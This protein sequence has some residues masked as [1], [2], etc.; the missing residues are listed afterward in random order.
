MLPPLLAAALVLAA[1]EIP[2]AVARASAPPGSSFAG[3]ISNSEDIHAYFSFARQ[4]AEG[5]WLF[6]NRYA[7]A[8][9][10]PAYF[11][12]EWLVVGWCVR[13]FGDPGAFLVWRAAGAL[14]LASGFWAL[15]SAFD[16]KSVR[17]FALALFSLGGGLGWV[18]PTAHMLHVPIAAAWR[19]LGSFP[20]T[21]QSWGVQPFVQVLSN[22][23]FSTVT[24][25]VLLSLALLVRAERTR[26]ATT[27]VAAG[28][29]A[30]L[31]CLSRP[32]E[33][34]LFLAVV[35]ALHLLSGEIADVRAG[36]R[37]ACTLLV[38]AP[39]L[40][41]ISVIARNPSF[42]TWPGGAEM[43]VVPL[44]G[45]LVLLGPAVLVLLVRI[46]HARSL[47]FREPAER[48]MLL[49]LAAA[50]VLSQAN[51]ITDAIPYSPQILISCM[52]PVVMLAVPAVAGRAWLAALVLALALP[53]SA[54]TIARRCHEATVF[55]S[56]FVTDGE[57]EAWTWLAREARPSDLILAT[58]TSG[59]RL[60]RHVSAHVVAGHWV[61]TPASRQ[62]QGETIAYFSGRMRPE[63]AA[64]YVRDLGVDWV[65]VGPPER[66]L[67]GSDE[68]GFA[69][70]C[71][72]C[73]DRLGVRI[74][75]CGG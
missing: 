38:L 5:R 27:Y 24:G 25:L 40:W 64:A 42:H 52:A 49:W 19:A 60:P 68:P 8:S 45:Y 46:L 26:R 66:K 41:P 10:D 22:P 28:C 55:P 6:E 43:P 50:L 17:L 37:R 2:Y 59:N 34:L 14:L 18:L 47:P 73:Y 15:T 71:T 11:N 48:V 61:W 65:W 20:Y 13:L 9:H 36:A 21:D 74:Y 16:R 32:Y 1:T 12:L 30:L 54:I 39:A 3:F 4:A 23:H 53:S 44:A 29:V 31:A 33:L 69:P 62:R 7:P 57:R 70:G 75:R 72:P 35:P 67:G 56:L 58:E 63:A 51:R